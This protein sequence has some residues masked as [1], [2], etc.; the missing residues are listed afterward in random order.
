MTL[1]VILKYGGMFGNQAYFTL[2]YQ[3]A[4]KVT[5]NRN[6]SENKIMNLDVHLD[7]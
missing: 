3:R 7:V 1:E 5:F 2:G 4:E 6:V